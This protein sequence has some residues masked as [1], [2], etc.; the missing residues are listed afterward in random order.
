MFDARPPPSVFPSAYILT[1]TAMV[2][3][4]RLQESSPEHSSKK[5]ARSATALGPRRFST[6]KSRVGFGAAPPNDE[7]HRTQ[8]TAHRDS[9]DPT[10]S[11]TDL[12]AGVFSP[13]VST[14]LSSGRRSSPVLQARLREI[15]ESRHDTPT[16]PSTLSPLARQP[17]KKTRLQEV[18]VFSATQDLAADGGSLIAPATTSPETPLGSTRTSTGPVEGGDANKKPL[19]KAEKRKELPRVLEEFNREDDVNMSDSDEGLHDEA[20]SPTNPRDE[21]AAP[22]STISSDTRDSIGPDGTFEED[23]PMSDDYE[24]CYDEATPPRA[25]RTMEHAPF[26]TD[27]IRFG[28]D[29]RDEEEDTAMT[30]TDTKKIVGKSTPSTPVD[31]D[32]M[33]ED[34][35]VG[36]D[37]DTDVVSQDSDHTEATNRKS[38]IFGHRIVRANV[39]GEAFPAAKSHEEGPQTNPKTPS[40]NV[41]RRVRGGRTLRDTTTT[42]RDSPVQVTG[43]NDPTWAVDYCLAV[44]RRPKCRTQDYDTLL[45][46]KGCRKPDWKPL[47]LNKACLTISLYFWHRPSE[48]PTT[49]RYPKGW[50]RKEPRKPTAA[51]QQGFDRALASAKRD[52]PELFTGMVS[53]SEDAAARKRAKAERNKEKAAAI[54]A[55]DARKSNGPETQEKSSQQAV[56]KK[57]TS[58]GNCKTVAVPA[59]THSRELR[60]SSRSTNGTSRWTC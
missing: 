16:T 3:K 56:S 30:D 4:R 57:S 58:S 35:R 20:S 39:C 23:F 54:S 2:P 32:G 21:K 37:V 7:I 44:R 42:D 51:W 36:T 29:A 14:S 1:D 10:M 19:S 40:G 27:S 12:L 43:G 33:T 53:L 60:P 9:L 25:R 15:W 38:F 13:L 34:G 41:A 52:F 46:W 55:P 31:A 26:S 45:K 17:Q 5:R 6:P 18:S 47:E 28:S 50:D 11:G 49:Y 59:P 24:G 22:S 8:S 48:K